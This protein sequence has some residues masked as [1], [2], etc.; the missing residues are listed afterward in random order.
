MGFLFLALLLIHSCFIG[1]GQGGSSNATAPSA[2]GRYPPAKNMFPPG[3]LFDFYMYM[4][5]SDSRFD[6][7]ADMSSLLWKEERVKYGDWTAGPEK[8]F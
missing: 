3:Q 4:S 2:A 7:F 6:G 8:V 5:D 1:G